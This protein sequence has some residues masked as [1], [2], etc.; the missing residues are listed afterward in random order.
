MNCVPILIVVICQFWKKI[1][2]FRISAERAKNPLQV[3]I[4]GNSIL[5]HNEAIEGLFIKMRG[6]QCVMPVLW[7]T[8]KPSHDMIIENNF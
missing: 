2:I 5:S 1:T 3:R 6:I 8:D 4:A 7:D